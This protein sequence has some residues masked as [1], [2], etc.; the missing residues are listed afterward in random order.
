MLGSLYIRWLQL[1]L[2]P[3][4]RHTFPS[5]YTLPDRKD[6]IK[7]VVVKMGIL[8]S[9]MFQ[10]YKSQNF[11]LVMHAAHIQ[12]EYVKLL[13]RCTGE[14]SRKRPPRPCWV[15]CPDGACRHDVRF[16]ERFHV[17]ILSFFPLGICSRCIDI[18]V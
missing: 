13:G 12:H 1:V 5:S 17:S 14:I 4:S 16:I 6:H 18:Q 11:V 3:D 10:P 8:V 2:H 9:N 7:L 15:R